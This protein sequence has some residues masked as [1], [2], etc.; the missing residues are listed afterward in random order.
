M[1]RNYIKVAIRSIRKHKLVSFINVFGL[2]LAMSVGMMIMVR[3]QDQ[4]SFDNFH[5]DADRTFRIISE[6]KK[7]TGEHWKMASTPLPLLKK[8][9]N[10]FNG[11]ASSVNIYPAFNG[12]AEAEG[13]KINLNGA[14]TESSLFEVFGFT[15]KYG[16]PKTALDQ[17]NAVVLSEVT[18]KK[19][20]GTENPMGKIF[21]MTNGVNYKVTGVMTEPPSRSHLE[22]EAWASMATVPVLESSDKLPQ[23][24]SLWFGMDNAYTYVHLNKSA[25]KASLEIQLAQVSAE[26]NKINKEGKVNYG[27]Q[28]LDDITPG[29][30]Q[31]YNDIGR[32]TSWS[33]ML[34]EIGVA[35]IVLLAAAFNYT[36]LNI[37]RALTRA[38]EVGIRKVAGAKRYQVFLQYIFE[39]V[40]VS[41]LAFGFASVLL[42]FILHYA[43]FNDGYEFIPSTFHLNRSYYLWCVLYVLLTGILA[44]I[45][46]A[47]I[48]SSFKPLRVLKNMVTA[49]IVG[50][51]SLQKTL[52]VFQYSLSLTIIIFLLAFYR[53][54]A[55]LSDVD[56]G[57]KRADVI[58]VPLEGVDDELA[59]QK[60]KQIAGIE[61]VSAM[62]STLAARFNGKSTTAW[63]E[64][65]SDAFQMNYYYAEPSFISDMDLKIVAGKNIP[66]GANNNQYILLNQQA[67]IAFGFK[68][69]NKAIG[70]LVKI[71]DSTSLQVAG[72][73][74][75]FN[76]EGAGRPVKALAIMSKQKEY[77]YLYV[78]ANA[79]NNKM[80][81]S[82][83]AQTLKT[84][85]PKQE[86]TPVWLAEVLEKNNSQSATI[87]LLGYLAFMA[88]SIATLGLLGLVIYTVETKRKEISIRKIIG[89]DVKQVL[90]ILSTGFVKLLFIA[91]FIAVPIG[92]TAAFFF[93]QGF[94][95]RVS[96][97]I[98]SAVLC[99]A[100]L[101]LL[102]LC[103]II[104]QTWKAANANA[105]VDLRSE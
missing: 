65:K 16:D 3:M 102:G 103:T 46:P 11:I 42:S 18:A 64:D 60:I 50:K 28:A 69:F 96:F 67:A 48:L 77:H 34:F 27:V 97:G 75:D 13:K 81:P 63:R 70:S 23:K 40:I 56:P 105:V 14:F 83:I 93:L 41:I 44:G 45:A 80:L 51:V 24:S 100:L 2:G 15:L 6:F 79:Q 85:S 54:F 89:A 39:S 20:F 5:P 86:F 53:Q 43:P 49:R 36:N 90:R 91:G 17:P 76:Y 32:G 99:F 29:S 1:I 33:K 9:R 104:S 47:W 38:K 26:L 101:L 84:I 4:F 35:L 55:Y 62:S 58:V 73:M 52:V 68:D 88:I 8:V 37:A 25:K 21:N 31:L 82:E 61:S 66:D 22:Y 87:S 12:E 30:E 7:T 74:Q 57:Y 98:G 72:I 59:S 94:A 10:D 78:K 71:N 19:Y 92:Y 95:N